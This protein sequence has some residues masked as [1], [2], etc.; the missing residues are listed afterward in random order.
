M[1]ER[2]R[3]FQLRQ[4]EAAQLTEAVGEAVRE[5]AR[6]V[7]VAGGD[8]SVASAA[9]AVANTQVELAVVPAGTLNHFARDH[10]IPLETPAALALAAE[11]IAIPADACYVND[12]LF[13]NTSSVGAYVRFAKR[14]ESLEERLGYRVASVLASL[15]VFSASRPF[16]LELD[17]HGH[18]RFYRT[19]L[20][21]IGSGER[22]LRIPVLGGRVK[23]GRRGLHVIVPHASSH[24]RLL[25]IAIRSAL[26]GV[27]AAVGALELDSFVV[28]HCR[29]D[30]RHAMDEIALD[31]EIVSVATPLN[32]RV[33]RDALRVVMP[34]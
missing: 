3:R 29:V 30:L 22:E 7:L 5:G 24:G 32:Y 12:Q 19:T 31:G 25:I 6:R 16:R 27:Q 18:R 11:G 17:V 21:F 2:D 9:S 34:A 23:G 8:G 10:E 4:V 26:R 14:R 20:A 13:L 28:D 1:I 33:A 15:Q